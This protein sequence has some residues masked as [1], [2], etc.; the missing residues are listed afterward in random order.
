MRTGTGKKK[1][2]F[3]HSPNREEGSPVGSLCHLSPCHC[4]ECHRTTWGLGVREWRRERK[5]KQRKGIGDLPDFL[6]V[7]CTSSQN[8]SELLVIHTWRSFPKLGLPQIQTGGVEDQ[9]EGNSLLVQWHLEFGSSSPT[10]L[11]PCVLFRF[12]D[13]IQWEGQG[14]TRLLCFIWNWPLCLS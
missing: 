3:P 5:K 8:E 13:C 2:S 11:P 14:G 7:N 12:Y 6:S 9:W 1:W 10:H 4:S